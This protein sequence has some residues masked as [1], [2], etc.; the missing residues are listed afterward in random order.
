MYVDMAVLDEE[1]V[2]LACLMAD[3]SMEHL[4]IPEART[5]QEQGAALEAE[6]SSELERSFARIAAAGSDPECILPSMLMGMA[7]KLAIL[8]TDVSLHG[9]RDAAT[10]IRSIGG[11]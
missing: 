10:V 8:A 6:F 4:T 2:R 1:C 9:D 3:R 7:G 11:R 5:P